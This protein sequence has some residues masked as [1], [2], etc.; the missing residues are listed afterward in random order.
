MHTKQKVSE[1]VDEVLTRQAQNRARQ[2]GESLE[3]AL[4]A[5]M[6]TEAGSQ[7]KELRVGPHGEEG[8]EQWQEGLVQERAQEREEALGWSAADRP[9]SH[10]GEEEG[11]N[12]G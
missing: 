2:R 7:L 9:T 6:E 1:M 12:R 11:A 3:D 5:I 8:A 10:P 4:Q